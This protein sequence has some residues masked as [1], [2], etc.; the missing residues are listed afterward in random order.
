MAESQSTEYRDLSEL[1]PGL[2]RS[3]FAWWELHG[4]KAPL[5]KPWMFTKHDVWPQPH[6]HL[7]VYECWIAEVM[8]QQTQLSV[9]LPYWHRWMKAFPTVEVL[10]AASLEAGAV[11]MARPWLLLAVASAP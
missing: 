1:A 6:E 4:R 10:V 2:R 9:M 8:L 11:A 5:L 7:C 3:L